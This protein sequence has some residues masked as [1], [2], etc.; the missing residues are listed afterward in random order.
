MGVRMNRFILTTS[1]IF[2]GLSI[3]GCDF[4]KKWIIPDK[5]TFQ[6][7]TDPNKEDNEYVDQ[8]RYGLSWD[9]PQGN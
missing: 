9:I 3:A 2:A 6:V 5:F 8:I 1:L 4:S 7:N